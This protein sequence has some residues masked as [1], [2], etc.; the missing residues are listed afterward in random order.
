MK[1][2]GVGISKT[3]TSSLAAALTKLGF[4]CV[5]G[6]PPFGVERAA[7]LVDAPAACRYREL[8]VMY[9]GSKFILT[10]REREAWL[11]SC[12]KHWERS[13][14]HTAAPEVRFEYFWCRAHI[15]GRLDF[16]AKNHWRSYL[17][18]VEEVRAYFAE[19]PGDLL[20]IDITGGAGWEP[21]CRFLDV[22]VPDAAFP[23]RNKAP[24]EDG[25]EAEPGN[26]GRVARSRPVR[27]DA[28]RGAP[29]AGLLP[30]KGVVASARPPGTMK[31]F[32]LG[33]PHTQTTREF[34]TCPFTMKAWQQCRMLHGRGHEVIHLGVEGS[35]PECSEN[36]A[37][38]SRDEWAAHYGHP[39]AKFYDSKSNGEHRPYHERWAAAVRQAIRERVSRPWEAIVACTWGDTQAVATKGLKQFVVESGIGYRHTFAKYRAFVSYAWLH[40]HYGKEGRP[41]GNGWY[42]VVIPNAVDPE[43]FDFRPADKTDEMLY[44]GRLNDD[45]GVGIAI[46]LAR[47][48][49]RRIAIVGQGNP[50]RFL[51]GNP[52]V[53]YLPPVGVEGRRKLMAEAAVL[54]CPTQY[55][56]PLGNVALEAQLSGTPVLCTDW[57]GFP[58]SV[59]HG[60]T[61][62]RCRTMEQ[63]VWA[64]K[65]ID[66][67]DPAA[68]RE[69]VLGNYSPER[70][71]GMFEEYFRMLLDLGRTGWYEDRPQR[72]QLDWLRKWHPA[73]TCAP[74]EMAA[75][76]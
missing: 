15:F 25:R 64:A 61:G 37:V 20:E 69:W 22:P 7:A 73:P 54:V 43:L 3:G 17:R 65:H 71:G 33:V 49:G 40:F 26:E 44:M 24:G 23:W 68:C 42:D 63:F 19:R 21:L 30:A 16:D 76:A 58:E 10:M 34:N 12:R 36:V 48:V 18:H 53:R 47:R 57:G 32:I 55:V 50:E 29:E 67:I 1:L 38:V 74:E 66:Q 6:W 52:H 35:D 2:I 56:E 45:K 11:E 27:I 39:G 4:R 72:E 31:I 51:A 8:D 41:Q 60:V 75:R 59:L 62:Y 14:L 28:A 46:D 13:R 70:I 9:P 5:H